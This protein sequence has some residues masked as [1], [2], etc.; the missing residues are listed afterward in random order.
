MN[1]LTARGPREVGMGISLAT[2]RT[3]MGSLIRRPG[4][5]VS[6][7]SARA[8]AS[9]AG[10]FR[11]TV[12]AMLDA[13]PGLNTR[14]HIVSVA[15]FRQAVGAKWPRLADKVA[16]IAD[17]LIR[18]HIGSGNAWTRDGDDTFLLLYPTVPRDE[19]RRRTAL[20]AEDI[21][22]HLL[23][24]GVIGGQRPVA[25]MAN[26][27][28]ATVVDRRFAVRSQAVRRAVD[29]G[30]ALLPTLPEDLDTDQPMFAALA[31]VP[32][33][34]VGG[35]SRARWVPLAGAE[36]PP[37]DVGWQAFTV[38]PAAHQ[39][40]PKWW[41]VGPLPPGARL[42]LMWRPTW[43]ARGEAISA[44]TARVVR[45]D[46][47]GAEPL[48][49]SRAYP[50]GDVA[51]ALTLDRFVIN[52]AVRQLSA[53]QGAGPSVILP[54]SWAT[55]ASDQR[56]ATIAAFADVT[57]ETRRDRVRVEVFD[58]P[59][60]ATG[61][62]LQS[63]AEAV[64]T[65]GCEVILRLRLGSRSPE[66]VASCGAAVIGLDLSELPPEQRMGDDALL[67]TLRGFQQ[68]AEQSGVKV[69]LWG[70]RRRRVIGRLIADGFEMVN[71]PGLMKDVGRPVHVVPAPRSRMT[72]VS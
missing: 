24:D 42:S 58:V 57:A 5:R 72:M 38:T 37:T 68:G 41:E 64:R 19:A 35:R 45:V 27:A 52:T 34:T 3:W 28:L 44:Y 66:E 39:Q 18:R 10:P 25:I 59:D 23:G 63:V 6:A 47:D 14:L 33:G 11:D 17:A 56:M 4:R 46:Y 21:S 20:I 29:S 50:P 15:D 36:A 49:G 7:A 1:L 69:A 9:G 61:D 48:E 22:R 54:L 43:V 51:T 53:G 65:L 60:E 30:R 16:M 2:L 13:D 55:L 70:A 12:R 8:S 40:K 31:E 62:N 32:T 67:E 71:G 26:I